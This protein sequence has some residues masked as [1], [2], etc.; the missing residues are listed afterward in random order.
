MPILAPLIDEQKD[1]LNKID[2]DAHTNV[3]TKD[4]VEHLRNVQ[5]KTKNSISTTYVDLATGNIIAENAK[6]NSK[7]QHAILN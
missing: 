6:T 1:I 5:N 4:F 7:F 3:N 2:I